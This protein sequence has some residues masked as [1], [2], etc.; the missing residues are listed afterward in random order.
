MLKE[1]LCQTKKLQEGRR[2]LGLLINGKEG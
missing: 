1:K 2:D